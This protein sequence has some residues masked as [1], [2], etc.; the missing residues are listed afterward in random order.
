MN[1]KNFLIWNKKK[2]HFIYWVL[3]DSA[4]IFQKVQFAWILPLAAYVNNILSI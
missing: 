2:N 1:Y 4:F 3:T